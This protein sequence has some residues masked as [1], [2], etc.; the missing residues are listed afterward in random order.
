MAGE[1]QEFSKR[2]IQLPDDEPKII[3]VY[4]HWLYYDTLPVFCDEP[5]LSGNAEYV[6]LVKAYV[7]G[8]KVLDPTFQDAT[9]DAI[10]EKS[11][12]ESQDGSAWFPVGEAIEYAYGNT[13]ESSAIIHPAYVDQP[14][15]ISLT[16]TSELAAPVM[17]PCP[18]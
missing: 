4:I 5:G 6:D 8:E 1:W 7:L 3:A 10:I 12:S 17:R 13:C 14:S 16:R 18:E 9:I 11:V 15:A 2:T